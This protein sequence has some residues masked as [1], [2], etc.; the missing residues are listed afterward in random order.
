MSDAYRDAGVNVASANELIE[1]I[2]P[3]LARQHKPELLSSLGGFAALAKVPKRYKNPVMVLGTDGVGTKLELLIQHDR[4]DTV[5]QD[6]VAMSVNDALVY[7]AEPALFLDY[8]ATGKLSVEDASVVITGIANAC[9]LAG[10]ALVGGETAEMPGFYNDAQFDLAGF[11]VGWVEEEAI[12][13]PEN[14]HA[15]DAIIGIGSSGPHS[16]G[17]SLIRKVLNESENP[18][19]NEILAALLEP[20]RI[21][22]KSVLPSIQQIHAIAHI[23]GGGFRDNLPRSFSNSLEAHITLDSWT[24]QPVFAWLQQ[25]AEMSDLD[26]FSTFNCGLG[27][28]LFV[29]PALEETVRKNLTDA[30]ESPFTIGHMQPKQA[31]CPAGTIVVSNERFELI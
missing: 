23:T 25:Q 21:Y 7:G 19:A 10:C 29:D 16:N 17:Y 5:G 6:L 24:K 28:I 13:K 22:A 3:A 9:E 26:M 18:P 12:L 1:S 8:Y 2:K 4:L 20:T 27:L 14:T 11:C 31:P 30:G 15:G